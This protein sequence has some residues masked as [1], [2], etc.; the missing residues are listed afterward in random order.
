MRGGET[1]ARPPLARVAPPSTSSLPGRWTNA[2][3]R[4]AAALLCLGAACLAGC[5]GEIE[6][7]TEVTNGSASFRGAA[8]GKAESDALRRDSVRDACRQKCA[9]EKAP[10]VDA[11]TAACA[12]D[13]AAQKLG[14]KTTCGRK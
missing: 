1:C 3:A 4:F 11:C 10:M 14:A 2:A 7:Q 9:A 5:S 6:C 13:V 12:A 8:T